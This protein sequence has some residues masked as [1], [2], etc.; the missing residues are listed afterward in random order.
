MNRSFPFLIAAFLLCTARGEELLNRSFQTEE[1]LKDITSKLPGTH[2]LVTL[3]DGKKALEL[4]IPETA[5]QRRN[6]LIWRGKGKDFQNRNVRFSAELRVD[7]KAPRKKWDG[8][9]FAVWGARPNGK[10]GIWEDS[11]YI[12]V[13]KKTWKTYSFECRFPADLQSLQLMIG[14]NGAIGKVWVRNLK[15]ESEET[16]F[17][18]GKRRIWGLPTKSR[19][20]AAAD[21][22]IREAIWMPPAFPLRSRRLPMSRS[23]LSIRRRTTGNPLS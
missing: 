7:L 12:G 17:R 23:R 9:Q 18:W 20:T 3:E 8:G 11:Q 2:S 6:V 5:E 19:A 21:G 22:T 14:S 4:R 1:S 16:S 10:P 15:I 13:G